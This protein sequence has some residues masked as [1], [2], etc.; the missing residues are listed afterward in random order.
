M[1]QT[2]LP[3]AVIGAGPVGLAAA[4]H[5]LARGE[6]PLVLEAG[7]SVGASILEWGHVRLFSPWRYV[8]DRRVRRLARAD[9]LDVAARRGPA[10][11]PRV[12]R[13]LPGAARRAAR[14]RPAPAPRHARALGR[15]PGLRQDEDARPRGGAVRPAGVERDGDRGGDPGQGRHRRLGHLRQPEPARRERPAGH[16]RARR[17]RPDRLRHP[18]CARRRPRSLR[19]PARAGRRQRPLGLQRPARPGAPGRARRRRRGSPGS[20]AAPTCA[21]SSAARPT[22]C[23]PRAARS[24]RWSAS[25]SRPAA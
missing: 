10:H 18:R 13:A 19:R 24:A 21:S 11:R 12:G 14:D 6:T 3:V 17:R 22:T 9:G 2:S 16:R 25:W 4:A 23:C 15:P 8:V 20:C 7:D 1:S 5:L